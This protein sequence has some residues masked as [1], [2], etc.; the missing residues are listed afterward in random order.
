M[1]NVI[2]QN[3]LDFTV[4]I[5]ALLA[6]RYL[7]L[8]YWYHPNT[9]LKVLFTA[10]AKRIHR[11]N[12]PKS[13]QYLATTLACTLTLLVLLTL[14][15]LLLEFA[16][17]PE[18]LSGLILYLCLESTT[19]KNKA[20]R[21]ARLLKQK[22]KATAKELLKPLL[23]RD[24]SRLSEVGICKGLIE[25]IILRSARNYFA[26]IF[27]YLVAGPIATLG[28][29]LLTQLHYAWRTEVKPDSA[30]IQPLK[31]I[32]FI[33]EFIPLRLLALTLLASKASKQSI[34]YIKH[35]GRHFYQTNSGWLLSVCSASLAIQLGGPAVYQKTKYHKM[36]VGTDR[37][38]NVDDIAKSFILIQQ[39]KSFWLLTIVSTE[40][41]FTLIDYL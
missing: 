36:R 37:L 6:E 41:A 29:H 23:A 26:V 35:Y 8:S 19:V 14:V 32:A 12:E 1:L 34:H 38:P 30:F 5:I 20:N 13:Y 22:Q 2:V 33:I 17:Y 18:L 10:L 16:Y 9:F 3:H 4:F 31:K 25:T 21:I 27:I 28:Y 11:P 7:P 39:A 40:L 15:I 24:T